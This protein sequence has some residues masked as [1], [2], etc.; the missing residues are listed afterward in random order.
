[1]HIGVDAPVVVQ[2]RKI[3][4]VIVVGH[5]LCLVPESVLKAFQ[6]VIQQGLGLLVSRQQSGGSGQNHEGMGIA[7]LAGQGGMVRI[8]AVVPSA[9]DLVP[10]GAKQALQTGVDQGVTAGKPRNFPML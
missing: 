6:G 10:H 9:V 3:G 8:Q 2:H 1:M 5:A 7:L 4:V